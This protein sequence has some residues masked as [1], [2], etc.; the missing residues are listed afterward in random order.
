MPTILPLRGVPA[1]DPKFLA[2]P[3]AYM[4]PSAPASQYPLPSEVATRPMIGAEIACGNGGSLAFT[5][6]SKPISALGPIPVTNVAR[7][8]YSPGARAKDVVQFGIVH[9]TFSPVV[10]PPPSNWTYCTANE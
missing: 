1:R 7:P 9:D 8:L 6:R 5:T 4:A 3:K 10:V 2:S